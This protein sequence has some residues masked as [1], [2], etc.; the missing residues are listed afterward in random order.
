MTLSVHAIAGT[1]VSLAFRNNP[2]IALLAAFF[3]HFL[4][5]AFSHWHY[6]ILSKSADGLSP[7]G[8]KL[9]FGPGFLKDIF[10]TGIDFAIGLIVSLIVSAIFFPENLWLVF[11]AVIASALPDA[12]QVFYYRFKNFKPL[13]WFQWLHEAIHSEKRLDNEPAKGVAQQIVMAA[14]LLFL[15]YYFH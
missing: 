5:D 7:F 13:Y 15:I 10:R 8:K 1:A 3:S 11:W 4:L 14:I 12:L 9:D 6:R 2:A